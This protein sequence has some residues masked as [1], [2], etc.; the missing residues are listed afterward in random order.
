MPLIEVTTFKNELSAE[1]SELLIERITQSVTETTSEK[2][3]EVTWVIIKEV[4]DSQWGVGGK[5]LT[6]A[7]VKSL[8]DG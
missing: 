8:I 4:N 3:R 6:L 1:Q 2:L 7:D 5:A